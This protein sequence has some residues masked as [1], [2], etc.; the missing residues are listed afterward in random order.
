LLT[1]PA[2]L[3]HDTGL[4]HPESID[5]LRSVLAALETAEFAGLQ[6]GSAPAASE[7][8]LRLVHGARL[9]DRVRALAPAHG[10]SSL[11]PDT[12]MSPGS[13]QA[14]LHAAGAVMAAVDAV[15]AGRATNAFCAVRPPGHHAEPDRA[16]GF[17]FFNNIAI[18]A[19]H[20]KRRHGLKRIAVV[21]F[22][23]HHGNGTQAAFAEDADLFFASTHQWGAYPGTGASHETGRGNILNI[24]L[25]PM[26]GSQPW[27]QAMA[28]QLLPRLEAFA[29]EMI[30]ISAGFDAH[31]A[32]P[33]AQMRLETDD[34]GWGTRAIC[35]VARK[36]CSGR[37]VSSLEG[38][39][40]LDALAESSAAHVRALLAAVV[41]E[42]SFD[43]TAAL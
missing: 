26:S 3:D 36:T 11:D 40:D 38:G 42:E 16:M 6:R 25:P 35:E 2:C 7:D 5:R 13:W 4:Y 10:F 14:A 34:F 23:V 28:R 33:L 8:D 29:P 19:L 30:L 24:P 22:D 21:D 43:Y 1:H 17:C 41:F 20:A 9:I 18:G 37:V 12:V 39:Y 15:M 32:D 31:K 27:R